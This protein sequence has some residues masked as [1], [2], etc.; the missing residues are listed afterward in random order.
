MV[1]TNAHST[2]CSQMQS[3]VTQRAYADGR[4]CGHSCATLAILLSGPL[5]IIEIIPNLIRF[6]EKTKLPRTGLEFDR[7]ENPYKR[8]SR[9][10]VRKHSHWSTHGESV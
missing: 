9:P 2:V 3:R 7:G 4:P 8:R 1:G 6:I 5:R 10:P